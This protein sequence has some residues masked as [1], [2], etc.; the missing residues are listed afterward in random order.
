LSPWQ[1][2]GAY[3]LSSV[4]HLS[5]ILSDMRLQQTADCGLLW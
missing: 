1:F 4:K 5:N 3:L 2:P